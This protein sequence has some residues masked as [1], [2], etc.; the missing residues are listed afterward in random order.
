MACL[1]VECTAESLA[2]HTCDDLVPV[3]TSPLNKHFWKI[4]GLVDQLIEKWLRANRYREI[5]LDC[6]GRS[7]CY[8]WKEPWVEPYPT[9][10]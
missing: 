3:N 6:V 9:N 5:A 4:H 7:G 10:R 8:Q 2:N 1:D